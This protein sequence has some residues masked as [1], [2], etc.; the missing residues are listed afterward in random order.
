MNFPKVSQKCSHFPKNFPK[1][2]KY[3]RFSKK[4]PKNKDFLIPQNWFLEY[5]FVD[6]QFYLFSKRQNRLVSSSLSFHQLF[7][8]I[9]ILFLSIVRPVIPESFLTSQVFLTPFIPFLSLSFHFLSHPS[10]IKS[11]VL[12]VMVSSVNALKRI[13]SSFLFFSIFFLR[14]RLL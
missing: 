1:M 5:L 4:W 13:S 8:S 7:L 9:F 2:M 14:M 12:W 6:G 3:R 10:L 11:G